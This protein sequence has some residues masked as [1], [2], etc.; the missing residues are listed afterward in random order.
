M[1]YTLSVVLILLFIIGCAN[2]GGNNPLGVTGGSESGYGKNQDLN[3]PAPQMGGDQ[4]IVGSW[5]NNTGVGAENYEIIT[6]KSNGEFEIR[7]YEDG[8]FQFGFGGDYTVS[9]NQI[10]LYYEEVPAVVLTFQLINDQLTLFY[11]GESETY[12]RV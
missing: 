1:K 11:D 9:G 5:R 12:Y 6:F 7:I 10:T 3:L 2:W 8:I 4:N